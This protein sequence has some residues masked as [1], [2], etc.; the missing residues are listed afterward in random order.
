[1]KG[2]HPRWRRF[3]NDFIGG[4]PP[5]FSNTMPDTT[6]TKAEEDSPRIYKILLMVLP[7]GV[8]VGTIIFMFM[9]FHLEREEE[10]N[11]SVIVAHGFRATDLEDM[12]DKF[13]GRIGLRDMNTKAGRS[14]LRR[15]ASMIEGRLGPQNVGYSVTRSDGLAAHGLLWRSLSVEV[16]GEKNPQEVVFAAV[17]FAGSGQD[18]DANTVSTMVMLASSMALEKPARTLRFVFIPMEDTTASKNQW[19]LSRCLK[20][21][22]TCAGIIGLETMQEMPSTADSAW[23]AFTKSASDLDWWNSLQGSNEVARV[24]EDRTPSVWLTHTVFSPQA[25]TGSRGQRI[26]RTL[27]A[28]QELRKWLV[29]AS[30]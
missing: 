18:A 13:T 2:P 19:L 25:W 26:E 23:Q 3:S 7:V 1:M 5:V 9:Y 17:S 20:P 22:E 30:Q 16:P 21:G 15:A 29:K 27:S 10:K 28:A 14:G 11:H 12:V 8:V 24:N 6:A 4:C